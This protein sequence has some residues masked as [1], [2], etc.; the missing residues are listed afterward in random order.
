MSA[1][2][3]KQNV[4]LHFSFNGKSLNGEETAESLRLKDEDTI[5]ATDVD[6]QTPVSVSVDQGSEESINIKVNYSGELVRAFD[7]VLTLDSF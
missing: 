4:E 1:C 2:C 7:S 3:K 6:N 5:D